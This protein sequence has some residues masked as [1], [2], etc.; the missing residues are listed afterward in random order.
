MDNDYGGEAMDLGSVPPVLVPPVATPQ[1]YPEEKGRNF[2]GWIILGLLMVLTIAGSL[3]ESVSPQSTS[4]LNHEDLQDVL[5]TTL[6]DRASQYGKNSRQAEAAK[7]NY[8]TEL[9]NLE[10]QVPKLMSSKPSDLMAR[11]IV[12]VILTELGKPVGSLVLKPLQESKKPADHVIAEIYSAKALSMTQAKDLTQLLPDY[13][14]VYKAI[15]V[16]SFQK[17]GDS[18]AILRFVQPRNSSLMS[19]VMVCAIVVLFSGYIFGSNYLRQYQSGTLQY[20]GIPLSKI[21]ALDA[22]RLAIRGA[23]IF[24]LYLVLETVVASLPKDLFNNFARI[25]LVIIGMVG[26]VVLLQKAPIDGKKFS[27]EMLGLRAQNWKTHIYL[28]IVGY[29]IEFPIAMALAAVGSAIFAFLPKATHPASEAIARDHSIATVLPVMLLGCVLA[30]FW[31]ELVFRG[32]LF[33]AFTRLFKGIRPGIIASSLLFASMHPQGISIW[34]SLSSVGAASCLLSYQS[35]SLV[36]SMVMHCLH[37]LTVFT[38]ALM[39]QT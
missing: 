16:Q 10:K 25:L 23:Q 34:L 36:P 7:K 22:D 19:L 35:K 21:T 27:L 9:K 26:G 4:A 15:K 18:K 30:P 37:N 11:K 3:F 20:L 6:Q 32:M 2:M 39:I 28:G 12:A 13:P 17:A 24:G 31:E 33:P 38:I 5:Q 14:P 8:Q 29:L 1:L